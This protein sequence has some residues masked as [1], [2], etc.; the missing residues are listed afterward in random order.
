ML[1]AISLARATSVQRIAGTQIPVVVGSVRGWTERP[2]RVN[3]GSE[4]PPLMMHFQGS[5]SSKLP[6]QN[7]DRITRSAAIASKKIRS[8]A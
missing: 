1:P 8:H 4:R 2:P 7:C 5:T 3:R 6:R